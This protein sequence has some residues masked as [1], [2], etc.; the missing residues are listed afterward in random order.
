[1]LLSATYTGHILKFDF[2]SVCDKSCQENCTGP[3]NKACLACKTG[4][5]MTENEGCKGINLYRKSVL[6]FESSAQHRTT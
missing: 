2:L 4:Y 1:M 6:D 5:E 3:G